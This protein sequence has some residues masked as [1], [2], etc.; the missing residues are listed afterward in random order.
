MGVVDFEDFFVLYFE[1]DFLV[2]IDIADTIS[3][4]NSP[5]SPNDCTFHSTRHHNTPLTNPQPNYQ[6]LTSIFVS[7][8]ISCHRNTS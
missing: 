1:G 6:G 8:H 5:N 4:H 3:I 2:C 7:V